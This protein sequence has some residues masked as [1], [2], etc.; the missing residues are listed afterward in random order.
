[1]ARTYTRTIEGE[2]Q[3]FNK[4]M[5]VACCDCALVH[6]YNY[7]VGKDGWL[8]YRGYRNQRATGQ[9]RRHMRVNDFGVALVIARKM[10]ED[11]ARAKRSKRK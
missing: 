3:R 10:R 4:T 6:T 5:N 7:R 11:Q 1:M 8:E 2:W 9:L